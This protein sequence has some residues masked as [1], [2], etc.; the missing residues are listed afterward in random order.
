[1]L[2]WFY[3]KIADDQ[4]GQGGKGRFKASQEQL[5]GGKGQDADQKKDQGDGGRF[6]HDRTVA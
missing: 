5:P 6:G 1:M 3:E 2:P 4:E